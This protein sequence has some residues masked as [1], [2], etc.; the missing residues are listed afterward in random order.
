MSGWARNPLIEPIVP[1]APLNHLPSNSD[2]NAEM[3]EL[4]RM[5]DYVENRVRSIR[6]SLEDLD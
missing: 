5:L 6:H 2:P 3:G 1:S 4:S